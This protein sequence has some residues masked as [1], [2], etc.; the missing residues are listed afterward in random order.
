MGKYLDLSAGQF[1]SSRIRS[2]DFP[3]DQSTDADDTDR[4]GRAA[5]RNPALSFA[6][7]KMLQWPVYLTEEPATSRY[8]FS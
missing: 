6:A 2:R 3:V 4:N 8:F 5:L 1:R 7:N